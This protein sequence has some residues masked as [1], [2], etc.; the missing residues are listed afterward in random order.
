MPTYAHVGLSTLE[1]SRAAALDAGATALEALPGCRADLALV[2]ATADHDH[3]ELLSTL[4]NVFGDTRLVGC[5]G[6]GVI[7]HDDSVE[8]FSAVAVLAV[9]SD[10]LRFDTFL[11]DDYGADPVGAGE[12]LA[13][14]VREGARDARCL[15]VLPDG[16][17]GDCTRFLETLHAGLPG[18]PIVGGTAADAMTFEQTFQYEGDRVVSGGAAALLISGDADVEIAVS[19]GCT[20]IGL[21]RTVTAAD[22]GW[23]KA[24][25]GQSAWS[26]FREYLDGDATDLNAE[27]IVHL[28]LGQ[29]L[30]GEQAAGYDPYVIRTPLKLDD[31]SGALFFPGGGLGEGDIVQMTRRDHGKIRQSAQACAQRLGAHHSGRTPDL[32]LQ[33]DCAGRGRV[34]F[35]SCAAAE[36]VAPLRAALGP[37]TPWI[38]FH[39]YGEIA[40][41]GG[42]P[43]YHNY[44]VAL[45]A[46]YERDVA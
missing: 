21:E 30:P 43:H 20:P 7:A 34:L 14:M 1:D 26:V 40:P 45:C 25:D 18:L 2:F 10:R 12:R 15:C 32:V 11:V 37:A 4:R 29:P 39:T 23:L 19:H 31:A 3:V 5:S 41:I 38:G 16:L 28:C 6:E 9:R 36:I 35:G 46:I 42:L 24:I 8:I 44:T 33:F 13:R 27:G 22:G 17:Q